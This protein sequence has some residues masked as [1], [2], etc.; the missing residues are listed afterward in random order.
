[1]VVFFEP[2]QFKCHLILT[3]QI[4]DDNC[5]KWFLIAKLHPAKDECHKV[6]KYNKQNY[7]IIISLPNSTSL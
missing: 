2:F 6:S 5:S 4:K 3:V 1:M 7:I